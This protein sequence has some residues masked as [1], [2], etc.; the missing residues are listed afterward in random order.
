MRKLEQRP[1]SSREERP[2]YS[3]LHPNPSSWQRRRA[4][5]DMC[6]EAVSSQDKDSGWGLPLVP[7][8]GLLAS[9]VNHLK[10][11]TMGRAVY[12]TLNQSLNLSNKNH[13]QFVCMDGGRSEHSLNGP[14]LC[15]EPLNEGWLPYLLLKLCWFSQNTL[16]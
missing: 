15:S 8:R 4:T 6:A 2:M 9:A 10:T 14:A 5:N 12:V 7:G 13:L 1:L 16:Y 3:G 11:L